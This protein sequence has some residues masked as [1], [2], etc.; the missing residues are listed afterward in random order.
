MPSWFRRSLISSRTFF[1][2]GR[3]VF[4]LVFL[5]SLGLAFGPGRPLLLAKVLGAGDP[6]LYLLSQDS[7]GVHFV[8]VNAGTVRDE[9]N[10][11]IVTHGWYEREPWPA[12]MALAIHQRV[13]GRGWCC[14]WYD[15]RGQ[16]SRLLPS[17]A[18]KLARDEAGPALGRQIVGLSRRWRHV[19]LIG[20]SAGSWLV[21]EAAVVIAS[22]TSA[23]IHVT[24]LDAYVPKGWDPGTLGR[25]AADPCETCWMEHYL[26]RDPIGR[27]TENPLARA[28]N[29]DVTDAN[30]GFNSHKFPWHWYQATILGGY[31]PD[32][33]FARKP[34]CC[35]ASG[36]RYGYPR[37]LEAGSSEWRTSLNLKASREPVR[38][39]NPK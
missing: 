2:P 33:R 21:N 29:I 36:L 8:A 14:G 25:F 3:L 31:P 11:V 35:E 24:F 27:L 19:H 16:A 30:P 18:A 38:V 12:N 9:P 10:L 4:A 7:N 5:L 15:W 34:V 23:S 26:T 20:H 39:P 22:Q 1:V 17:D 6:A 28:C 37:S 32:S 13:D